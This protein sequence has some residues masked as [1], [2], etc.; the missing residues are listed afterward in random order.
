MPCSRPSHSEPLVGPPQLAW[1]Y[2][3]SMSTRSA[4]Y[5]E[6]ID[7]L[8]AGAIL[9]VPRVGW[10]QYEDLLNDLADRPGVR[11]S[12]DGGRLEIMSPLLEH[13]EYKEFISDLAR[14]F[15]EETGAPLEKRGSATWKRRKIQKGVEPDTC[16]YVANAHQIVGR[17][18]IDL[19]SDPPPDI[20]VEIDT[21]NESLSKFP[22]YAALG[23]PEIWRYDGKRVQMY[24][25]TGDTYVETDA[26]SFFRDLSSSM[27]TESL[28]LS[29][30]QS[31][32]EAL[33]AFR[34]R[35]RAR[36]SD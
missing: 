24:R 2:N 8:P 36:K 12:Y 17:R 13:E 31:Q 20:A 7:H 21:T 27:L 30:T 28:E 16:F 35:I 6:A 10:E 29:K 9:V 5:L 14:A 3:A 4:E 32:T 23:V 11:V 19:E 34:Q 26:S 18:K 15:S 1:G 25:L 33:K 22:I